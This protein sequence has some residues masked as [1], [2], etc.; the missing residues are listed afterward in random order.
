MKLKTKMND[1]I[2]Q[3]VGFNFYSIFINFCVSVIQNFD[4]NVQQQFRNL[5]VE[6]RYF[7]YVISQFEPSILMIFSNNFPTSPVSLYN[8]SCDFRTALRG[9]SHMTSSLF[10]DFL[11]PSPPMSSLVIFSRPPPPWMTSSQ[12]IFLMSY[13]L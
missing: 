7:G 6:S 8:S 11:T 4:D 1:Y 9:C 12:R 5:F 13:V 3:N 2:S 10:W